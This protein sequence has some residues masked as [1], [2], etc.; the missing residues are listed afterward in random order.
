MPCP[1]L[2]L[3]GKPVPNVLPRSSASARWYA[4]YLTKGTD[5]KV[6]TP[7]GLDVSMT[8]FKDSIREEGFDLVIAKKAQAVVDIAKVWP[9]DVI[10]DKA[11]MNKINIVEILR[12]RKSVV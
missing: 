6:Y 7:F 12:D 3:P 5:I 2:F 1:T 11:R 4:P 10:Y 8:M 9:K